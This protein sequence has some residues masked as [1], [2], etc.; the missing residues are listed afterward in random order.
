MNKEFNK[1]NT[2]SKDLCQQYKIEIEA[3]KSKLINS[4][5]LVSELNIIIAEKDSTIKFTKDE[6][7][8]NKNENKLYNARVNELNKLLQAQLDANS[9]NASEYNEL[10][11]KNIDLKTKLE[12]SETTTTNQT[13]S[14][15]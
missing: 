7:D 10:L 12:A 9:L 5:S 4:Q 13:K 2:S 6:I 1:L 3:S 14:L 8:F 11:I 15:K